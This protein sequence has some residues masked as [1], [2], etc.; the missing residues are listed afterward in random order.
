MVTFCLF[1]VLANLQLCS[2]SGPLNLTSILHV[3]QLH[4]NLMSVV[5]VCLDNNCNV[6]FN[7][8]CVCLK[9]NT[10]GE[11]LLQAPSVGNV[12]PIRV[13]SNNIP[14]HIA[15]RESDDL[16]HQRLG[17]CGASVLSSLRGINLIPFNIEFENNCKT[18]HLAKSQTSF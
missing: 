8:S 3:L 11:V 6:I 18:C 17:H 4:H 9:D 14:A 7:D 16:W 12:Y 5:Q 2:P 10:T 15:V 1:L 13:A